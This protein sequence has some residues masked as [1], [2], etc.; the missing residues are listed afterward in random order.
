MMKK[1]LE[2]EVAGYRADLARQEGVIRDVER[3]KGRFVTE[4]NET[5]AKYAAAVEELALR[6]GA[7]ADLQKRIAGGAGGG[8]IGMPAGGGVALL[9]G[10]QGGAGDHGTPRVFSSHLI[11]LQGY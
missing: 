2:Q 6:D 8:G 10:G 11:Q 7:V 4:A 9:P 3:E 1:N 5:N